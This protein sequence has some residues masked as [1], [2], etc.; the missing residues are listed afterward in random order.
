[1]K[2][3]GLCTSSEQDKYWNYAMEGFNKSATEDIELE[4]RMDMN[5]SIS[6]LTD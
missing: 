6:I 2:Y 3:S 1:M 5:Y 4:R